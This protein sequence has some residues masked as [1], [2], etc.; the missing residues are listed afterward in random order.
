MFQYSFYL[1]GILGEA[2]IHSSGISLPVFKLPA[3]APWVVYISAS[4][5][6]MCIVKIKTDKGTKEH[7]INVLSEG[8]LLRVPGLL[9]LSCLGG[10]HFSGGPRWF[11]LCV[12]SSLGGGEA[13]SKQSLKWRWKNEKTGTWK[14]KVDCGGLLPGAMATSDS[15]FVI[16]LILIFF[17]FF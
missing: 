16:F 8:S 5:F 3:L 10:T 13:W 12:R 15:H 2:F 14:P 17:S 7:S 6:L 1:F 11:Q 9:G 4:F